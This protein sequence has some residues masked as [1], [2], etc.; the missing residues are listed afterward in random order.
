MY[1]LM[2]HHMMSSAFKYYHTNTKDYKEGIEP[3]VERELEDNRPR[4]VRRVLVFKIILI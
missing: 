1:L 4:S 2:H 3:E